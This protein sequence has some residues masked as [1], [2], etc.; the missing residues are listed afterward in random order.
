[1]YLSKC[2]GNMQINMPYKSIYPKYRN[3]LTIATLWANLA[4]DK[5]IVIF[6]LSQKPGFDIS[7]KLDLKETFFIWTF[8]PKC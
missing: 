3:T 4:D 5:L 1:M 2:S 8:Y 6:Y 7:C